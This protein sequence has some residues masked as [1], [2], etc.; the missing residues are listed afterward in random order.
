[1]RAERDQ[2]RG[3]REEKAGLIKKESQRPQDI[4]REMVLLSY[5]ADIVNT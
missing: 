3:E 2:D 4:F 5:S 1:M